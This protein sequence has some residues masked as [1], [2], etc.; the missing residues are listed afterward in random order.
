MTRGSLLLSYGLWVGTNV[1][2]R[3]ASRRAVSLLPKSSS[4]LFT[5]PPFKPWHP[6][7]PLFCLFQNLIWLESYSIQCFQ[8]GFFFFLL[9]SMYLR[10]MAS[11]SLMAYFF[12]L[13]NN[14]TPLSGFTTA[15]FSAHLPKDIVVASESG[16]A[17]IQVL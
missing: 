3:A 9:S 2:I 8:T 13:L 4:C 10:F 11:H 7:S 14:N 6:L 17:R 15:Y 5:P 1:S 16:Q 12:L